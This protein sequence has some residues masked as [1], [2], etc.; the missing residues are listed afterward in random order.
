MW[1]F[2]KALNMYTNIQQVSGQ[3]LHNMQQR[4]NNCTTLAQ[5]CNTVSSKCATQLPTLSEWNKN[6]EMIAGTCEIITNEWC[7]VWTDTRAIWYDTLHMTSHTWHMI[8]VKYWLWDVTRHMKNELNQARK[9]EFRGPEGRQP[10]KVMSN[11]FSR[12]CS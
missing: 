2:H 4:I 5:L 6:N 8:H 10:P 7:E 3:R 11:C 12:G 1:Y 9:P